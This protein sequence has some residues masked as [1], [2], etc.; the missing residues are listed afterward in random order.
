[1][2]GLLFLFAKINPGLGGG[3]QL[4]A[5]PASPGPTLPVPPPNPPTPPDIDPLRTTR[6]LDG[7]VDVVGVAG[8]TLTVELLCGLL[9][10]FPDVECDGEAT[11]AD[12]DDVDDALECECTWWIERID[13][14][15][16]DVDL[17]PRRP[18]EERR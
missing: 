7:N 5:A 17:R 16:L 2:N 18:T 3:R 11:D 8:R 6:M 4:N 14:T 13:E 10:I 12:A 15:E 9:A 1:L